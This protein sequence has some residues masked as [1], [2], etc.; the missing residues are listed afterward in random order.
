MK[1]NLQ[2]IANILKEPMQSL[3]V[4]E[5]ET[6]MP[7][8]TTS[9]HFVLMVVTNAIKHQKRKKN[10]KIET[11]LKFLLFKDEIITWRENQEDSIDRF[12]KDH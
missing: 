2:N 12:W 7:T 11:K 10:Y 8:I 3:Y 4:W 5:Q 6:R 1:I 9:I